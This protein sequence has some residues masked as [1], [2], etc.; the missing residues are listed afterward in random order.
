MN[1][2]DVYIPGMTNPD[3]AMMH[4]Y[5]WSEEAKARVRAARKAGRTVEEMFG[6]N[7]KKAG[8][9]GNKM[10]KQTGKSF[11][12]AKKK[13]RILTRNA[14][15]S[16]NR[17]ANKIANKTIYKSKINK[18]Q[19][20]KR[21]VDKRMNG[22][23][24]SNKKVSK[25]SASAYNKR[26]AKSQISMAKDNKKLYNKLLK[27]NKNH[28]T[29]QIVKDG[30][31]H[32][33]KKADKDTGKLLKKVDKGVTNLINE[34]AYNKDRAVTTKKEKKQIMNGL[35]K[36]SKTANK[37]RNTTY[38]KEVTKNGNTGVDGFKKKILNKKAYNKTESQAVSK[39]EKARNATLRKGQK[40]A[41]ESVNNANKYK[42]TGDFINKQKKKLVDKA[43]TAVAAHNVD[44]NTKKNGG[45]V[46]SSTKSKAPE[47][48]KV[49]NTT[50]TFKEVDSKDRKAQAARKRSATLARKSQIADEKKRIKKRF[51][52]KQSA[53]DDVYIPGL[54]GSSD[55]YLQ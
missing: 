38:K 3:D 16:V 46:S 4:G 45:S 23:I 17:S 13:V 30:A 50:Y 20:T 35:R 32:L 22:V 26:V 55:A 19:K 27:K 14:E 47:T 36:A 24:S 44:K 6:K 1:K 33:L 21:R 42:S 39:A 54:T 7:W 2:E 25:S 34:R 10:V 18:L 37:V 51:G 12:S 5:K 31:K 41:V 11:N 43:V 40:K 53:T 52:I 9:A 8:K 28:S 48:R 15:K 29:S 49:G